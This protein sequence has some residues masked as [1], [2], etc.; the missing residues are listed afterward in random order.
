MAKDI[1]L[2]DGNSMLFRAYHA[3]A[4][5]GNF[6]S[7]SNGVPTNAVFGFANMINKAI[8]QLNPD[9]VM[10]AWDAGKP[11]FRHQEYEAYKGTRKEIDEELKVQFPIA[12]EFLDAY[13]IFRYE[14]EGIE[15]DDIIGSLAKR[16]PQYQV[17][18]LSS[19]K[20]LLQLIDDTTD[21][22][23]MKKG[24]TDMQLVNAQVLMEMMSLQPLQIIDFKGLSGDSS[25]NIPGVKGIGEKT[26]TKLLNEYGSLEQVYE[27]LSEIKGKLKEKLEADKAMAF[28]SKQ[29][30]TIKTDCQFEF[31]LND[32]CFAPN[33]E[34]LN[35]F[36]RKYE[37][38]S[39]VKQDLNVR[40]ERKHVVL[41]EVSCLKESMIEENMCITLDYD[42]EPYYDATL[43]GIVLHGKEH[44]YYMSKDNMLMDEGLQKYLNSDIAKFGYD[45]KQM[46]HLLDR[47]G[48][49]FHPFTFDLM[50]A[51]FLCDNT[52]ISYEKWL[53]KYH[54]YE[55]K[56]KSDIYGKSGKPILIDETAKKEFLAFQSQMFYETKDSIMNEIEEKDLM[57]ILNEMEM[58]LSYL[59]F[60]MEKEGVMIDA[61]VLDEIAQST[62]TIIKKLEEQI[63]QLAGHEF[64]VNSPKQL[65]EV[66]FDELKLK[67]NKKRSTAVDVLEKLQNVHP[68]IPLLMSQRKYQKI[69]ST[70]AEGLKKYVR[71]DGKIHTIFNQCL[72]QTGRLS[73]SEP[74]LQNISVRDEEAKQIRKAFIASPGHLMYTVDYS[75]I[76]LR[77]L[78]H[79]AEEDK[80]IEAFHQGFD[81]HTKTAMDIYGVK[82]EEV[83][84]AM[85]REAKVVNFGIVY[86]QT[87]FGLSQ[88]LG[89]TRN[90]AKEFME[91]YFD[92]YP[93]IKSFMEK[94]IVFCKENGYV[95]TIFNRRRMIPEINDKNYMT[96][97]FGKR[98][99]MNAPIQGSAADLIKLAMIKVDRLMKEHH[100]K[101][102]MI[103]QV[104][105]E[106]IFDVVIEEQEILEEIVKKGMEHVCELKVPLKADGGFGKDYYTIK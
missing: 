16:Y 79:M 31:D 50:I 91:R 86:G 102:K 80:M 70:Y 46:Y 100:L 24:I 10:V 78:A 67:S 26:A 41:E 81:I 52:L 104:H 34:T 69:Y 99:A 32:F 94:T 2:I 83:T 75:Q 92:S 66:L 65:A 56:K 7:T 39:L 35:Q 93:K 77:M 76:E 37:M 90:E 3:T 53:D 85:R 13:H 22:L 88:E 5:R 59:L 73:S 97:E 62:L 72:T 38:N 82:K 98:A 20:D 64:N 42:N 23:L 19:D 12:R 47:Y 57:F 44:I 106:L 30:A 58:P 15:A 89:I 87:E 6:M 9:H 105:D 14:E 60:Q 40:Q 54:Y 74:N 101:S 1:L 43:Y 21:V 33:Y 71:S 96:R 28:L 4:Y 27:H 36:F 29:L 51:S 68:I 103:L 61:S 84:S 48:F 63:Y 18:I 95:T 45:V 49:S 11:T 55:E 25:D 17:H 8:A